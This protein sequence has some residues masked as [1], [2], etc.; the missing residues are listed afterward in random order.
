MNRQT[1]FTPFSSEPTIAGIRAEKG[2]TLEE[3]AAHVG[4]L[5]K[6]SASMIENGHREPTPE[7][8]FAIEIW[9][10]GRISAGLLNRHVELVEKVRGFDRHVGS[11][12]SKPATV[13]PGKSG[14]VTAD[15][16]SSPTQVVA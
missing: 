2:Q 13:S 3:F 12:N 4:L 8:A 1:T 5:S 10:N 9:S 15:V 16:T 14:E 11:D 6:S 7:V